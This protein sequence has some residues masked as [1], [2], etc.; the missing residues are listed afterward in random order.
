MG[1]RSS[2]LVGGFQAFPTGSA[3]LLD[4]EKRTRNQKAEYGYL[5]LTRAD[6]RNRLFGV[7]M[8]LGTFNIADRAVSAAGKTQDPKGEYEIFQRGPP[9]KAREEDH[10]P[11][12]VRGGFIFDR[13]ERHEDI[14]FFRKSGALCPDRKQNIGR[15]ILGNCTIKDQYHTY[16]GH[17]STHYGHHVG[18][19]NVHPV[20]GYEKRI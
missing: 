17:D 20:H 2:P 11:K 15:N 1:S 12:P 14:E 8:D 7:P 10:W 18:T 5:L 3:H 6:S 16:Y 13:I 9:A 4:K 19:Y